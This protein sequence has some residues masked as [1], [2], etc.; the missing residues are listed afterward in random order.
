MI[1]NLID[2]FFLWLRQHNLGFLRVFTFIEF[3]AIMAIIGAFLFVRLAG[4]RVIRQ[5]LV[6]KVGDNPEFYRKDLNEIMKGKANTPTMGGILISGAILVIT[7][8]LADLTSFY[9]KMALLCLLW[10]SALGMWDDWLKLTAKRRGAGSREGLYTW[11]KL[12]FQLGLAVLLGIFIHHHG[13]TNQAADPHHQTMSHVFNVPLLKTWVF[14]AELGSWVPAHGSIIV[15]GA[16]S[17]I[18]LTVV[19]IT[20][21][22]NAVNLTDGMD[23]L[24]SGITTIAAFAFMMLALIAGFDHNGD[25]LAKRLLVPYIPMSDELAVVAGAMVGACLGFLWFNASPAQVFMGDTGSLPLGG[26]LGYIAVVIRQEFL[27]LI[28][29]G[30]FVA[31]AFS[32]MMQVSYFKWTKNKPGGGR[33]LFR[34][35]PIHYHFHLGGWT[36]NQVVVRFWI[37]SIVLAAIALATLRL[38]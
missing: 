1:Y 16:L 28:I 24:A 18:S 32:V 38:R 9:V 27:L 13:A 23:G 33:R 31:E 25:I 14:N 15:L 30:V 37:I 21:F 26:L 11:E 36:E 4:G 17:F 5:L 34:C 8:L 12:I 19:V 6:L 7:L 3:R 35:A 20:F 22:S 29:G 10:L 2:Y